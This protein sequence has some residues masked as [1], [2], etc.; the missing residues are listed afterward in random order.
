MVALAGAG[1]N[2]AP[3][4]AAALC[5][6]HIGGAINFVAVAETLSMSPAVVSA[7]MYVVEKVV[8]ANLTPVFR[9][10]YSLP[11]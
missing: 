1:N 6:R 11:C 8:L 4:V 10:V 3:K 2:D 7:A 5:A 9:E